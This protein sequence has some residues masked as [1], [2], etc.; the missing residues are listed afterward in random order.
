[1]RFTGRKGKIRSKQV[2]SMAENLSDTE[3]EQTAEGSSQDEFENV[4]VEAIDGV[5]ERADS[6]RRMAK[7][8]WQGT[9]GEAT[10]RGKF[11]ETLGE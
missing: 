3:S 5:H 10:T 9:R 6:R 1:M 11:N 7:K 2:C 4:E 8:I